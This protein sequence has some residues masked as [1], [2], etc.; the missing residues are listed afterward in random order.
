[1]SVTIRIAPASSKI[2]VITA[3]GNFTKDPRT[4]SLLIQLWGAGG[5]GRGGGNTTTK[6]IAGSGGSYKEI[7]VPASAISTTTFVTI[8]AGGNG[9]LGR[10]C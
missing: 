2:T 8:G 4:T 3:S 6:G 10:A 5:G 7:L 1:M 9:G